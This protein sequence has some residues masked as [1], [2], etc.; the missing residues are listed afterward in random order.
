MRLRYFEVLLKKV[1]AAD[2]TDA[3]L[4]DRIERLIS[5]DRP[6]AKATSGRRPQAEAPKGKAPAGGSTPEAGVRPDQEPIPAAGD[7]ET[8]QAEP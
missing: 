5:V 3:D 7:K 2:D 8:E 1:D 6:G 4:L